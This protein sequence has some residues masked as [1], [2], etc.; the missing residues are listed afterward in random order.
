MYHIK[1]FFNR[2]FSQNCVIIGIITLFIGFIFIQ[3][4][5]YDWGFTFVAIGGLLL[6]LGIALL[7]APY[8]KDNRRNTVVIYQN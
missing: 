7:L 2:P 8:Q 5:A 6:F 4:K 3:L 1:K